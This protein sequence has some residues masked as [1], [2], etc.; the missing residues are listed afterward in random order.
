MVAKPGAGA[1]RVA[2]TVVKVDVGAGVPDVAVVEGPDGSRTGAVGAGGAT[3]PGCVRW[4]E[5]V[6]KSTSKTTSTTT[7]PR[8][9]RCQVFI[10]TLRSSPRR[11]AGPH[12]SRDGPTHRRSRARIR[13]PG[14]ASLHPSTVAGDAA[15]APSTQRDQRSSHR[16]ARV[17]GPHG[18]ARG[19][20][21]PTSHLIGAATSV[22]RHLSGGSPGEHESGHAEPPDHGGRIEPCDALAV[23]VGPA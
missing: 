8:V 1:A 13:V 16:A 20:T 7:I 9:T 10:R 6:M 19:M 22:R 4:N 14:L 12:R 2:G 18:D 15:R 11:S 3:S 17:A 5:F 23:P 21:T